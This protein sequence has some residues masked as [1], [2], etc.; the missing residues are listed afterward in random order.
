MWAAATV[1][2]VGHD[3]RSPLSTMSAA[4]ELL[5]EDSG[6]EPEALLAMIRRQLSHLERM[7]DDLLDFGRLMCGVSRLM[8]QRFNLSELLRQVVEEFTL[9]ETTSLQLELPSEGLHV[10]ADS[11]AVRRILQNLIGNAIKFSNRDQVVSVRASAILPE[12]AHVQ[13]E[14]Q[15]GSLHAEELERLFRPFE[16]NGND[17]NGQGL[18]LFIVRSLADAANVKLWL[19]P[20]E[21]GSCFNLMLSAAEP[22]AR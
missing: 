13:I 8:P 7:A 9:L 12:G 2:G 16:R 6:L 1:A 17:G 15:A 4:M 5:A 21:N 14:D 10:Y 22:P 3:M 19:E 20:V 11:Y 18:G